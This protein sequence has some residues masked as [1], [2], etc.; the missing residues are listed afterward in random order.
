MENNYK[1]IIEISNYLKSNLTTISNALF[2]KKPGIY[3]IGFMGDKFPW[4]VT[5][6]GVSS[7]SIIYIGK[8][9]KSSISRDRDGHFSSGQ[10]GN[11]T[12]RRSLGGI[13]IDQLNLTP[14]PRSKTEIS[15]QKYRNYKFFAEGEDKLTT[16]MLNNLSLSF[17]DFEGSKQELEELENKLIQVVIPILNI[18]NNPGNVYRKRL[19]NL[20]RNCADLAKV[21]ENLS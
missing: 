4:E 20:R 6:N 18:R 11:S 5:R 8:T 12:L 1:K 21:N 2:S 9:Q 16:W 15:I 14:I 7:N 13:L 10:S 19:Q 3:S 17:Y